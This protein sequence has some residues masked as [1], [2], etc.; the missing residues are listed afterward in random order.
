MYRD[1]IR[2]L[3]LDW[4]GEIVIKSGPWIYSAAKNRIWEIE[5]LLL[6]FLV[7]IQYCRVRRRSPVGGISFLWSGVGGC[8]PSLT[9][10]YLSPDGLYWGQR[11]P[12]N[13]DSNGP[14][15]NICPCLLAF[16]LSSFIIYVMSH[17]RASKKFGFIERIRW[18]WKSTA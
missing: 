1:H 8:R 7:G 18:I 3:K 12:D 2:R 5:Y 11:S 17:W 16:F 15:L 14:V 4:W 9:R 6:S 10:Q 13:T